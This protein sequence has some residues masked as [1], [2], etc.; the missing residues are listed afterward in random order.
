MNET[1]NHYIFIS[2]LRNARIKALSLAKLEAEQLLGDFGTE[3]ML[4]NPL[5]CEKGTF[6]VKIAKSLNWDLF[7][8]RLLHLGYTNTVY[9]C[10]F[11]K[12]KPFKYHWKR[13]AFD[14]KEVY[15]EDK[16]VL[17]ERSPN[18]RE[19]VIKTHDGAEKTVKGYR[20]SSGETGKRALPVY[21]C[22]L[23]TNLVYRLETVRFLDPF[24][25]GGGI[26]L[27]A[28]SKNWEV[29]S[30]DIDPI[31]EPGLL[32][33]GAR[34]STGNASHIPYKDDFFDAIATEVPFSKTAE[35]DIKKSIYEMER[36]IKE[37]CEIVLMCAEHQSD[38]IRY[39][40]KK[41]S[42]FINIDEPLNRKGTSCNIFRFKKLA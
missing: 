7:L 20:G 36:V 23:M 8:E 25:G 4:S 42:L 39:I 18:N 28:K 40:A 10:E 21:D 32:K 38:M 29:Y 33:Y 11:G 31:L 14:L 15:V 3:I 5:S 27:E 30:L 37:N 35:E 26:V 6:A 16:K 34:H 22:K 1:E 13:K 19:F 9:L 12:D 17:L 2:K 24:A 41:A